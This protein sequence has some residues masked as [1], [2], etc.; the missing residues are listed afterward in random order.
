MLQG[1]FGAPFFKYKG[2]HCACAALCDG[3]DMNICTIASG[4]SGNCAVV[5]SGGA[6]MLVDAGVSCRRITGGLKQLNLTLADL[7][8]IWITH[9]HID[10]IR[11]LKVISVRQPRPIYA[12]YDT[13]RAL[14]AQIPEAAAHL[15]CFEPG[16]RLCVGPF[17]V[18]AYPTPHDVSGSVCYRVEADGHALAIA[19]DIGCVSRSV[20]AA[21]AGA[22]TVVVESNHDVDML[23]NGPYPPALKARILSANGHLA[24]PDC[25][26]FCAA[27]AQEGT[28]RFILAH[29]SRENNT[30]AAAYDT[31]RRALRESGADGCELAVAPPDALCGPWEV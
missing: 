9:S 1:P 31:V 28:R 14:A 26:N 22:D 7:S 3:Y 17:T 24:N 4:S 15:V 30:P 19:T 20:Y 18:C 21:A 25:G 27:L 12:T 11:A 16:E 8:A 13:A 6:A 23:K 2:L 29:L 5:T 10:H